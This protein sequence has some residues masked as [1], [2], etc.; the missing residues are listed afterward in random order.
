MLHIQ[1]SYSDNKENSEILLLKQKKH[2][3]NI[4]GKSAELK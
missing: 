3:D 1:V 2:W 4:T